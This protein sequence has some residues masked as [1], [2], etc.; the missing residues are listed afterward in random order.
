MKIIHRKEVGY[1]ND[2]STV[3]L[4]QGGRVTLVL[5]G[6]RYRSQRVTLALTHFFYTTCLKGGLSYPGARITLTQGIV[7]LARGLPYLP[8]KHFASD[9]SPS[10]DNLS[11]SRVTSSLKSLN[12]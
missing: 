2:F 12:T 7:I 8:C 4:L 10:K 6:S 5:Q 11:Q 3:L 1:I 9:N